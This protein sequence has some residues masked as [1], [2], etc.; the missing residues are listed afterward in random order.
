MSAE[1]LPNLQRPVFVFVKVVASLNVFPP[2]VS[3]LEVPFLVRDDVPVNVLPE[4][5]IVGPVPV[6]FDLKIEL[7]NVA[8]PV[9]IENARSPLKVVGNDAKP[10]NRLALPVNAIF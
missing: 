3:S 7:V 6:T 10:I 9:D 8:V 5:M 2:F 1:E 4:I